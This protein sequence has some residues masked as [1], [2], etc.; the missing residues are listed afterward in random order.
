MEK[1]RVEIA[2][3]PGSDLSREDLRRMPYLQ[4]VLKESKRGDLALA[5]HI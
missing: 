2:S 4:N 5:N 1:L 3:G